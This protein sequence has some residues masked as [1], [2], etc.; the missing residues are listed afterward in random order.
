MRSKGLKRDHGV[1]RTK[2]RLKHTR[3]SFGKSTK[4]KGKDQQ[5]LGSNYYLH[6][7]GPIQSPIAK[8][9]PN[10][11]L[12]YSKPTLNMPPPHPNAVKSS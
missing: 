6:H 10:W 5:A 2:R 11:A 12:K 1:N 7:Q 8:P 9:N 3:G 4:M